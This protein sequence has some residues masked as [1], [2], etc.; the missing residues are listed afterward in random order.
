MTDRTPV[1]FDIDD[2]SVGP[3]AHGFGTTDDGHPFAFRTR[4][5]TLTVEIYRADLGDAV[6]EAED[7]VAQAQAQVTDIDLGDERSVAAFV[8][9][10][11]LDAT[12]VPAAASRDTTTM[13]G[14]LGRISAAID[15]M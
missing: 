9:D 8:R 14:I 1:G 5:A 2:I 13:R 11:L 15:G 6:P 7:V 4:R 3:F 12:P 10:L